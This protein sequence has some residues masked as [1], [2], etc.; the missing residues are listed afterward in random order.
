MQGF[1]ALVELDNYEFA[2][3]SRVAVS[4][5]SLCIFGVTLGGLLTICS[6]QT[7]STWR[8]YFPNTMVMMHRRS[9]GLV[10]Y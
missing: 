6:Q 5:F 8:V 4:T 10:F 7:S 1:F 2:A 3:A 9:R